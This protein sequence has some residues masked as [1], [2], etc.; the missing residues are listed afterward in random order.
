M[1]R[2]RNESKIKMGK[3]VSRDFNGRDV[4]K[5]F[6]GNEVDYSEGRHSA[7]TQPEKPTKDSSQLDFVVW[8]DVNGNYE[9]LLKK[10]TSI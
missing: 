9:I 2:K 6:Y 7:Q 3:K 10:Y 5:H 4:N 1:T 8:H